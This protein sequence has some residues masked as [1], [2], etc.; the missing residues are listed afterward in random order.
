VSEFTP[1]IAGR[2][3]RAVAFDLFR[4]LADD[5]S[6]QTRKDLLAAIRAHLDGGTY[7]PGADLDLLRLDVDQALADELGT[8][9]D[10]LPGR[11]PLPDDLGDAGLD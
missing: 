4:W 6:I 11:A 3:Q 9:P 7:A 10:L 8:E 1:E 2:V 5:G